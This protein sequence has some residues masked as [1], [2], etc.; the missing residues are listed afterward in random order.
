[1]AYASEPAPEESID[2]MAAVAQLEELRKVERTTRKSS[3]K[4]SQLLAD[5][6]VS[7][8]A[9]AQAHAVALTRQGLAVRRGGAIAAAERKLWRR[10]LKRWIKAHHPSA[11][12]WEPPSEEEA[13]LRSWFR[14]IDIDD[15]RTVE[16]EEIASLLQS[17]GI[18]CSTARLEGLFRRVGK[19]VHEKLSVDDFVKMM[20]F[21]GASAFF[22]PP[23]T[24]QHSGVGEAQA[25]SEDAS[26]G[27]NHFANGNLMILA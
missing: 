8:S 26:S 21:G 6:L 18:K 16:A 14:A 25:G 17:V 4:T 3:L 19:E 27:G 15:S 5:P 11:S 22:V 9:F 2:H 7:S 13:V 10:D 1:M 24:E 20:H 12:K 23:S